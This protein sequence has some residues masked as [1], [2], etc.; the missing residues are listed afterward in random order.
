M[1]KTASAEQTGKA[2][3]K[4]RYRAP[5]L[6]KGLE[7]LEF[8]ASQTEPMTLS[9]ISQSLNRSRSEIF[10]MV[11]ELE[12]CGY[13]QHSLRGDGYE[14]TNK[15]FL[16]G[17]EQ[18][19]THTL[20]E[21]ALPVMR[22]FSAKT[23]Q[24]CHIAVHADDLVVVIARMEAP[25]PV[26]L[27][28]RVGHRMALVRSTS[29]PTIFAY[30]P[31]DVQEAL[32]TRWAE[33]VDD[34]DAVE[35]RKLTASIRKRGYFARESS[36][37]RGVKDLAAPIMRQGSAIAAFTAPCLERQQPGGEVQLPIDEVCAAARQI[38][39]TVSPR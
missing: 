13:I 34:F 20:L 21:V 35:F 24:S 6:E 16:L 28:V 32:L 10:R 22:E 2:P 27:S 17:L 29:G 15:L 12:I 19:R 23:M 7:I 11:Q 31:A 37:V 25:V 1:A 39:E 9:N 36:Y 33:T 3:E 26:G 4:V 38:S 8:L 18:P 14:I 5:A 30:Q